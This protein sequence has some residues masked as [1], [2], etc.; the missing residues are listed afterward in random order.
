MT[1]NK[2][3][4][5]VFYLC[6]IDGRII[7]G[8]V[9]QLLL[10]I[11]MCILV[12]TFLGCIERVDLETMEF[13]FKDYESLVYGLFCS[14]GLLA[15]MGFFYESLG[16]YQKTT[17]FLPEPAWI[18]KVANTIYESLSERERI[19]LERFYYESNDFEKARKEKKEVLAIISTFL[20]KSTI[21]FEIC[22]KKSYQGDF[23]ENYS[24]Y[25]ANKKLRYIK[26][27]IAKHIAKCD[28]E[29][30]RTKKLLNNGVEVSVNAVN[31]ATKFQVKESK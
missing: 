2:F 9:I 17:G 23:C 13:Q 12:H 30:A 14:I 28:S 6:D 22:N 29:L 7:R 21:G 10:F 31:C 24:V 1:Q 16:F 27:C 18:M 20:R 5:A 11:G 19:G 25:F 8:V 26:K 15:C 4:Q 3:R